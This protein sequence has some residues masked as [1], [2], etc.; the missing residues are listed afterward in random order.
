MNHTYH[1]VFCITGAAGNLGSLTARYMLEHSDC[2]LHL[3]I[4]KKPLADDLVS[5]PRVK[6]FS[7]DLENRKSIGDCFKGVDAVLHYASVL[8]KAHPEHFM[9]LTNT[10]YFE[11]VILAA[12]HAGVERIILTSFPHVEGPTSPSQPST[13]RL[14]QKP[15]SIH[16]QTRLAEERLLREYYPESGVILRIGMVYGSGILMPDAGKWFARYRLLGVWRTPTWIHLI[17]RDDY[18]AAVCNALI[19]E[20]VRGTYNLGDEGVQTLQEFLDFACKQ[21]GYAPP[22]RMPE[23]MIYGAAKTF[24]IAST[25]FNIPSPLTKDFLDIGHISYYGDTRRMRE[26][27]LPQLKYRTMTEGAEIF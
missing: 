4:H 7:C 23:W 24:E 15:V 14:D 3:M 20:H 9:P 10:K 12:K 1:P 18:L 8:F 26:D 25:L 21:W 16:A 11:N 17:S 2:Y 19:K 27:L 22:W 13:D 5:H 6:V